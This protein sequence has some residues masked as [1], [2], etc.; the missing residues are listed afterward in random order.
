[1]FLEVFF[2][3]KSFFIIGLIY[4]YFFSAD[5]AFWEPGSCHRRS[6]TL[7]E[8]FHLGQNSCQQQHFNSSHHSSARQGEI[9][10]EMSNPLAKKFGPQTMELKKEN[11]ENTYQIK[12]EV[13]R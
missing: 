13:T 6:V 8:Y 11:P 2:Y 9:L 4:C 7:L 12:A 1:M 3:E 10:Y 5:R